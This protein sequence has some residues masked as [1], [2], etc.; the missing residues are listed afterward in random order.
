MKKFLLISAAVLATASAMFA[1]PKNVT[2]SKEVLMDKIKGGWAAQTI[3]VTYG[4]PTEFRYRSKM[5]PDDVEIKWPEHYVKTTMTHNKH[6]YD[7][8][9]MDLTF[10]DVFEKEG[11]DAP[12]EKFA[13]AFANAGY[14]LWHANQQA[15]YNIL[16]GIM[17]P[18]S[19]HWLNNPHADDID[20][21]IEADYAGLMSPGMTAAACHF[22]DEIGHIM[23][24]G[25]GWYGGVY[26]AAM[27]SL[28]FIYNDIDKIV[29]D[30]LK[31]IPEQSRFYQCMADVIAWH[32]QYPTDWKKTWQLIEEK[33]GE[34][35][36]CPEGVGQPYNID[37][38]INS[39]YILVGLLYGEG[40]FEKTME[41]STRCGQ[42]SDC[43]PAS[44]A[45][46]LGTMNG[47]SWIPAKYLDSLK[48]AEDIDF[49]Y[50]DISLNKT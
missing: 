1:A 39:A 7:D 17:P 23:N 5:I 48:E 43:N 10:V 21:Q 34:D 8:I 19:G 31:V 22:C 20:F 11:L 2:M 18:Y 38:V 25:D 9:Y 15:R 45:G 32:K 16:H 6:L 4:G 46:I 50:T 44:A 35:I 49:A 27:Y 41:I 37:A 24:Y 26:V 36:G 28:A 14:S 47:Y 29:E 12:I 42:D 40:D 33:H 30:A 3:G 13:Y